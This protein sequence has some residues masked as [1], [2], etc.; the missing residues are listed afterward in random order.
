MPLHLKIKKSNYVFEEEENQDISF[1]NLIQNNYF[2]NKLKEI[3]FKLVPDLTNASKKILSFCMK[4]IEFLYNQLTEEKNNKINEGLLD[5]VSSV[6]NSLYDVLSNTFKK[7]HSQILTLDKNVLDK[8][9][10]QIND[11]LKEHVDEKESFLIKHDEVERIN[12]IC[13]IK[14]IKLF[15]VKTNKN[16]ICMPLDDDNFKGFKAVAMTQY[17]HAYYQVPDDIFKEINDLILNFSKFLKKY[18]DFKEDKTYEFHDLNVKFEY[19]E[20]LS[21][22][23]YTGYFNHAEETIV[24]VF[25]NFEKFKNEISDHIDTLIHEYIHHM[26]AERNKDEFTNLDVSELFN[27]MFESYDKGATIDLKELQEKLGIKDDSAFRYLIGLMQKNKYIYYLNI[28]KTR[29]RDFTKIKLVLDSKLGSGDDDADLQEINYYNNPSEL[30]NYVSTYINQYLLPLI[31]DEATK[32]EISKLSDGNKYILSKIQSDFDFPYLAW[33]KIDKFIN[34]TPDII[35]IANEDISFL[36]EYIDVNGKKSIPNSAQGKLKVLKQLKVFTGTGIFN[37]YAVKE[38]FIF[39]C[40]KK[41]D[42]FD[43]AY[44]KNYKENAEL[45][46]HIKDSIQDI[47]I[48]KKYLEPLKEVRKFKNNDF[49]NLIQ[50]FKE[51]IPME[52]IAERFATKLTN[53]YKRQ[54]LGRNYKN[55]ESSPG[56]SNRDK[57]NNYHDQIKKNILEVLNEKADAII[58]QT[59]GYMKKKHEDENRVDIDFDTFVVGDNEKPKRT[60]TT[61]VKDK[62]EINKE[63]SVK[64]NIDYNLSD[65]DYIKNNSKSQSHKKELQ[66]NS[67]LRQYISL[68]IT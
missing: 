38:Q 23:N 33:E 66:K 20:D 12:D 52:K 57:I 44:S 54:L 27:K 6:F 21:K 4:F 5:T 40:E 22:I 46:L 31:N 34:D 37:Y 53:I 16:Y 49:S 61:S 43:P 45:F 42:S 10:I 15:T 41:F 39:L 36:N 62:P 48:D 13:E 14:E 68:L 56:K 18:P 63:K 24:I 59:I 55:R 29:K 19:H 58:T 26:D 1:Q 8:N 3:L 30:N 17:Y 9:S 7:E 50:S 11:F 67:L 65:I 2:F 51:K 25:Q 28:G 32:N 60:K 35:K 47:F 64:Y